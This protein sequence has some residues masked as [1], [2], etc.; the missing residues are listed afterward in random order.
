MSIQADIHILT[1]F[2]GRLV[3]MAVRDVCVMQF[4]CFLEDRAGVTKLR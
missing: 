1:N 4:R 2:G 3:Q